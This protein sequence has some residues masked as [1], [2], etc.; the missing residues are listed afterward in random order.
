ME[1]SVAAPDEKSERVVVPVTVSGPGRDRW[2]IFNS[3][4]VAE[5][6]TVRD[7][8]VVV[9]VTVSVPAMSILGSSF[10]DVI[11]SSAMSLVATRLVERSPLASVCSIPGALRDKSV[12]APATL[13][14]PVTEKLL[15][16]LVDVLFMVTVLMP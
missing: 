3:S 13:S 12:V 6:V 2:V 11:A 10:E 16:R 1:S 8:S 4:I 9:S 15:E 7:E 5:S 14:V